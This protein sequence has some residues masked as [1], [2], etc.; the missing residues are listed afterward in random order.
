V[1]A[2]VPPSSQVSPVRQQGVSTPTVF[3]QFYFI[4]GGYQRRAV[5]LPRHRPR[6]GSART[7]HTGSAAARSPSRSRCATGPGRCTTR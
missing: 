3:D 6:A 4:D 7:P 5:R 2:P 1:Q